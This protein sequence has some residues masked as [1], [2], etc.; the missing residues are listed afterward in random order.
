M[1]NSKSVLL[2]GLLLFTSTEAYGALSGGIPRC[3]GVD[4]P[5]T[6]NI[7][8]D[9]NSNVAGT[10]FCLAAGTY[11]VTSRI[12]TKSN[13]TLWGRGQGKTI[14]SG[15]SGGNNASITLMDGSSLTGGDNTTGVT[16]R[17]LTIQNYIVS[18]TEN[19]NWMVRSGANWTFDHV[20]MTA[21]GGTALRLGGKT[22]VLGGS[23]HDNQ[24]N[25]MSA[26]GNTA[27]LNNGSLIKGVEVSF[28]NL[29][30]DAVNNDASG[31]KF[32]GTTGAVGTGSDDH[33][34][35]INNYIHDNKANGLWSDCHNTGWIIT[36]NTI[37]NNFCAGIEYETSD[38]GLIAHN[39]INNNGI[40]CPNNGEVSS[41]VAV[42][43][44]SNVTVQYNNCLVPSNV[45]AFG[46]GAMYMIAQNRTDALTTQNDV[47]SSNIITF[48]GSNGGYGSE[49]NT[50]GTFGTGNASNNNAFYVASTG[51]SHWE[52]M[53]TGFSTSI[54][55][56]YQT[57]SSQDAASTLVVGNGSRG[58]GCTQQDC[59]GSGM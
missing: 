4:V 12:V 55:S 58:G 52:W 3:V 17:N 21:S 45:N 9:I 36:G 53:T 43:S 5:I 1:L 37:T 46:G 14:I 10:T 31:I 19:W 34:S 30:G 39:V 7:A 41:C 15:L 29:R 51:D 49:A 22:T 11:T 57:G 6:D 2:L 32:C 24:H 50:G 13:I 26:E 27:G 25:G 33:I 42:F 40:S 16:L 59:S 18:S 47:F 28:N 48:V 54:F 20:E 38:S 23:Y 35:F 8:T 44:S 56:T